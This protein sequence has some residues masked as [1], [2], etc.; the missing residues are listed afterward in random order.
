MFMLQQNVGQN[1]YIIIDNKSFKTAV[2]F[3]HLGLTLIN[4]NYIHKKINSTLNWLMFAF[5]H[6]R[7]FRLPTWYLKNI[8]IKIFNTMI[9]FFH[10]CVKCGLSH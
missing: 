5:N 7:I 8:N 1:Q 6:F 9:L 10:M 2:K 3:K 4:Q